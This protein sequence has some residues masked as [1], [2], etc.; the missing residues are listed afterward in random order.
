MREED[1]H[2]DAWQVAGSYVL[3]GEESTY[4]GV[5]PAR[6]FSIENGHWGAFEIK[7]RYSEL[8]LDEDSFAGGANSFADPTTAAEKAVAWAVG[9]NWYLNQ[10]VKFV[11]DYEHTVFDGG[12]GGTAISPRDREDENVILSRVQLAF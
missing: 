9:F 5:K 7:A 6:P 1:F 12:G 8:D 4:K 10:N 2:H 11:V 3:T